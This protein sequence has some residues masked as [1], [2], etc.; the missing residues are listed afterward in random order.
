[1]NEEQ[2]R[3]A[4]QAVADIVRDAIPVKEKPDVELLKA[5]AVGAAQA[6]AAGFAAL[7]KVA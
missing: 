1:M 7:G 5:L 6:I 4:A 3:I 2:K